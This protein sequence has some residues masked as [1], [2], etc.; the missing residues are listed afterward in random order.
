MTFGKILVCV[1]KKQ[2][3]PVEFVLFNDAD[4]LYKLKFVDLMISKSKI[5]VSTNAQKFLV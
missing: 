5:N 1:I 4:K 2:V 3:Q